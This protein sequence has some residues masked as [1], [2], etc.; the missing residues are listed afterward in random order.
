VRW[1][2]LAGPAYLGVLLAVDTQATYPE[3]LALGVLTWCVFVAA[4]ARAGARRG[5]LRDGR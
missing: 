1:Y 2:A 4:R 3:Q 5:A